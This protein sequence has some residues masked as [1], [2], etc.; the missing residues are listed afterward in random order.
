LPAARSARA[1]TRFATRRDGGDLFFPEYAAPDGTGGIAHGLDWERSDGALAAFTRGE[2]TVRAGYRSRSKGIPTGAFG[3]VF[4]DPRARTRDVTSWTDMAWARALTAAL[5]LHLRGYADFYNYRG[6]YPFDP[7]PEAYMEVA[8]SSFGG[9]QAMTIWDPTSRNRVTAA[10]EIRFITQAD[11]HEHPVGTPGV[12]AASPF[13]LDSWFVQDELQLRPWIALVGGLGYDHQRE[14][15]SGTIE[16]R[17]A[18]T[19]RLA[20]I[21][22]PDSRTNIK[23]L[24]GHAFRAPSAAEADF[25]TSLYVEN[26]LLQAERMST[27]EADVQRRVS[28]WMLLNVDAYTYH[29][30]QLIDQTTSTPIQFVNLASVHAR[31]LEAEMAVEPVQWLSARLS[32]ARQQTVNAATHER[33]SNSPSAISTAS[34]VARLRGGFTQ[35]IDVRHETGRRT[36]AGAT[37]PAFTRTDVNLLYAPA[38]VPR[39]FHGEASLRVTNLFDAT[40]YAPGGLEHLQDMIAQ[41][42]RLITARLSWRW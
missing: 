42:R 18:V 6:V 22:N 38:R 10:G 5:Q 12:V 23:L 8:H 41:D 32:Y 39:W 14:V 37:T 21:L 19:P 15:G 25:N 17:H 26:P 24:Y 16:A 30:S 13:R 36:L 28:P 7:G 20:A 33:L 35:A 40:Y 4:N 29:V 34:L 31:G 2:L 3:V 9:L 27:L 1:A 11:V